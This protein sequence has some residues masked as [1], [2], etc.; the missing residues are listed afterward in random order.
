MCVRLLRYCL[1]TIAPLP[2]VSGTA[3][4]GLKRGATFDLSF[5][6]YF[7]AGSDL[8]LSQKAPRFAGDGHNLVSWRTC[9]RQLCGDEFD[10]VY[11]AEKL[12]M[13]TKAV[14]FFMNVAKTENRSKQSIL[15]M[16]L[17][18]SLLLLWHLLMA[19]MASS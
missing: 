19:K 6:A 5:C 8:S 11:V 16:V 17:H 10:V 15:V 4:G 18:A 3:G 2:S 7:Q 9:N 14:G 12:L 1:K 13:K